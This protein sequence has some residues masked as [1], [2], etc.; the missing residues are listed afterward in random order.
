MT[1]R[2]STRNST[3]TTSFWS[4]KVTMWFRFSASIIIW[5]Y[6]LRDDGSFKSSYCYHLW[7]SLWVSFEQTHHSSCGCADRILFMQDGALPRIA[8]PVKQLLKRYFGNTWNISRHFPTAWPPRSPDLNPC[9]LWLWRYLKDVVCSTLTAHLT[10][11]KGLTAQHILKVTTETL[12][13][14]MLFLD[15]NFLQKMVASILNVF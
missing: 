11:S 14:N 8:N 4:S 15:F 1:K 2:K 12:L 6:F 3:C 10:E 5:S 7:S 9:E 13:W